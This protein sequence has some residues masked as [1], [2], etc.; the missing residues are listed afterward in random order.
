MQR[1][2]M[3]SQ[4]CLIMLGHRS[5]RSTSL[6][7]L[8][9]SNASIP[10]YYRSDPS[11]NKYRA[12]R[13]ADRE[14]NELALCVEDHWIKFEYQIE[15]LKTVWPSIG[16]SLQVHQNTLLHTHHIKLQEANTLLDSTIGTPE[17]QASLGL[18]YRL[19]LAVIYGTVFPRSSPFSFPIALPRRPLSLCSGFYFIFSQARASSHAI[20]I[21][22]CFYPS[23][24]D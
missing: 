15:F 9:P 2:W 24:L 20:T 23:T 1:R 19:W 17:G 8:G 12:F 6:G 7:S 18:P 21:P 22:S 11:L 13:N 5:C 4:L 10:R 14:I 16:E 3:L